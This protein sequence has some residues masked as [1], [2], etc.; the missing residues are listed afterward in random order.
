MIAVFL[1]NVS[2]KYF[3]SF[4]LIHPLTNSP[5]SHLKLQLFVICVTLIIVS[6]GLAI[7]VDLL[8][9]FCCPLLF[10]PPFNVKFRDIL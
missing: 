2:Q 6:Q 10:V 3:F 9:S 1:L 4:S 5:C 7:P 8:A